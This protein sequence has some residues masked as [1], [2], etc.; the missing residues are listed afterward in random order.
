MKRRKGINHKLYIWQ[1]NTSALAFGSQRWQDQ[2]HPTLSH[3]F[4]TFSDLP[5]LYNE[6]SIQSFLAIHNNEDTLTQGHM[7][8]A[9]DSAEFIKAQVPELQGL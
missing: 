1:E 6:S 2:T 7:L 9:H 5:V 3:I 8:K 4:S